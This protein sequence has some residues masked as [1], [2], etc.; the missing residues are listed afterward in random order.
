MG[1]ISCLAGTNNGLGEMLQGLI[2]NNAVIHNILISKFML[3]NKFLD[4]SL[5]I[6][7]HKICYM[8]LPLYVSKM[9][10]H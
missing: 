1:L 5:N 8:I 6:L 2:N 7:T 9:A 3:R 10:L 4:W